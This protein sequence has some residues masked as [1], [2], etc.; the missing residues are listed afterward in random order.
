[1]TL[2]PHRAKSVELTFMVHA[3]PAA[4]TVRDPQVH[5]IGA[6]LLPDLVQLIHHTVRRAGQPIQRFIAGAVFVEVDFHRPRTRLMR[7]ERSVFA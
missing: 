6:N 3:S 4:I 5:K 2:K 1:M 7:N